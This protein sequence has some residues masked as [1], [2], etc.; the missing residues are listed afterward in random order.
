MTH[1][2][3]HLSPHGM[4]IVIENPHGSTR[5]GTDADGKA[6]SSTMAHHYGYVRSTKLLQRFATLWDTLGHHL[7]Q[8]P[9][10]P[11]LLCSLPHSLHLTWQNNPAV[12]G[13]GASDTIARWGPPGGSVNCT[14]RGRL[15]EMDQT[16]N[17]CS[18]A[19]LAIATQS[20]K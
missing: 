11:W 14:P 10:G 7:A 2:K 6:W 17:G 13:R 4:H 20:Y 15:P 12:L 8:G 19:S 5:S 16:P 18:T 9:Y 3:G 1:I